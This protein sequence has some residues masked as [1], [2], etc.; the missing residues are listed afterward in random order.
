[1]SST[2]RYYPSM[3]LLLWAGTVVL[4]LLTMNILYTPF[5]FQRTLEYTVKPFYLQPFSSWPLPPSP[6]LP[7]PGI[8]PHP[9][10]PPSN[11]WAIIYKQPLHS[12]LH[13]RLDNAKLTSTFCWLLGS[14][15][16][17]AFYLPPPHA[18]PPHPFLRLH[19]HSEDR[20]FNEGV[21][22]LL[23]ISCWF[24]CSG[25]SRYWR[26]LWLYLQTGRPFSHPLIFFLYVCA[27]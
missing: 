27:L 24:T 2:P 26:D 10:P 14:F 5:Y 13:L 25:H 23:W 15:C 9:R 19:S 12:Q 1:M 21:W 4:L 17:S 7:H 16:L 8:Y 3:P 18:S 20:T 22:R 11:S 6:P